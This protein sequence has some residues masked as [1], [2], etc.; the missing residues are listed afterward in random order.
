M[1]HLDR[2]TVGVGIWLAAGLCGNAQAATLCVNPGGTGGC[3]ATINA[4]VA[5][6]NTGDIIRV[7]PGTYKEDVVI[8]KPVALV[9]AGNASTVI[10]AAGL[11]NGVYID[12]LDNPGLYNVRVSGFTIK[13]A[14][15]EGILMTNVS[16]AGSFNNKVMNNN[17]ALDL[18]AFN[19]PGL[20]AFETSESEDCGEGIH[21][22]G[23]D[24]SVIL[25]NTVQGNA[26]GIL[27]SDETGVTHDNLI[28]GNTVSNNNYDCGIT[29]ASHPPAFGAAP[30]GITHNTIYNNVSTHNGTKVPGAG[31]GIGIFTFLPGGTV[32]G[33]VVI[34]NQIT[35]N[36][37]P[38]VAFHAHGTGEDLND[39]MI[40][41]NQISGNGADTEDAATPG[42]TGVNVFG[43]SAITGTIVV[44]NTIDGEADDVVLNTPAEA[45]VN[46]NDFLDA[47][48]G[49]DNIGTGTANASQNWWGCSGG[50]SAAGCALAGGPGVQFVPWLTS[51]F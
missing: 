1:K 20:P 32:S 48:Y 13:N 50:P 38:G 25:N 9:G 3:Y 49:V 27:L 10:D 40:V 39:N 19:C 14:K 24:H 11:A 35:N 5:A 36:G 29:M 51:P 34:G 6:A 16:D 4:A 47:Q 23:A 22:I 46:F 12:G 31:A 2:L 45:Q 17:L 15:F 44:Q 37:L 41:A 43:L 8:G 21:L 30:Y 42:T 18:T 26:G 33:N 7:Q 28:S